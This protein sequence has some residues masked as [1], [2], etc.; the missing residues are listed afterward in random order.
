MCYPVDLDVFHPFEG[1][2]M[3]SGSY[4]QINKKD[5]IIVNI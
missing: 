1:L 4:L 3:F 5:K 2:K